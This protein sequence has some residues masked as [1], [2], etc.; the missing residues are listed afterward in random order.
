MGEDDGP[1]DASNAAP[2]DSLG[3]CIQHISA[4]RWSTGRPVSLA[5]KVHDWIWRQNSAWRLPDMPCNA[6]IVQSSGGAY[7]KVLARSH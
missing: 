5:R 3:T 2:L 4:A 6:T 7:T 1:G